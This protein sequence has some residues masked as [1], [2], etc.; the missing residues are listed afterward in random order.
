MRVLKASALAV[1]LAVCTVAAQDPDKKVAGGGITAKGWQG[2]IDAGA[3]KSGGTINDSKFAAMGGGFH[4]QTGPAALYWNPANTAKG[5]YTVK[6]SFK[7]SANKADHPHPYGIFIGGSKL[8]TDTPSVL[9]CA[10]YGN[11]TVL[12]RGFSGGKVFTPVRR[13]PN[14]AAKKADASGTVTQDIAWSVKGDKA[15]CMV[16]GAVVASLN[17]A[18]IV[19]PDK[20]DSTDGVYGLRIAH[21]IDVMVTGLA[22]K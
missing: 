15:E 18:D 21:N 12:V 11:G 13:A 17:K 10:A 7:E 3:T 4:V 22:S 14:D 9:Y 6:A 8:D 1:A 2:K 16:N 19:G 20:L 5:D